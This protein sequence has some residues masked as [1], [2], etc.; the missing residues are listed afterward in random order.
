MCLVCVNAVV[1]RLASAALGRRVEE[2]VE[3]ELSS[4]LRTGEIM[5]EKKNVV[6]FKE[7]GEAILGKVASKKELIV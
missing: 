6:R 2:A 1:V 3:Q 7:F 5:S 4:E